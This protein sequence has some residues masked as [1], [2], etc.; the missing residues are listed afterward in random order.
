ML[1]RVRLELEFDPEPL[2]AEVDCLAAD[3]WVPHF[4]TDYYEGD[5]SGV[6]LRSVGGR[7]TQLYPDPAAS[8]PFADTA[9][10]AGSPALGEALGR[11]QCELLS[12]RLLRL[13]PG[14]R[15]REHR[16]YNLG[17]EDGEIRLHIPLSTSSEVEFLHQG[18]PVEMA[19]GECWYLDLN[20]PHAVSNRGDHERVHLVVD[21]V[22]NPWLD[23]LLAA[24]AAQDPS[25]LTKAAPMP[26]PTTD[27]IAGVPQLERLRRSIV[28]ER[29]RPREPLSRE[30]FV[31]TH[32]VLDTLGIGLEPVH[33]FMFRKLPTAVEFEQWVIRQSGG[34]LDHGRVD[35]ANRI[36]EGL[37]P[38][39]E[40]AAEMERLEQAPP[41]LSDE[42]LAFFDENGYVILR[43]AAP[44][45][46]RRALEQAIWEFLDAD[47]DDPKTWYPD[48][49]QQGIMVQMFRAPGIS[50]IH[51]SLRIRKA[52]AQLARTSDL[53]MTADRCGF[54]PPVVP[55]RSWGGAKLHLDLEDLSP[56]VAPGLQGI[57]YLT[58]TTEEQGAFRCVPGFHHRIDDWL[59]SL[60]ERDRDPRAQDLERLGARSIAGKAGD[61]IIWTQALPHGSQPN[62]ASRPR[63][64]HYLT[65]YPTPRSRAA[66][67]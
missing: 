51:A 38:S 35:S 45:E 50:E 1:S 47:P 41:V 22:V 42:D 18:E 63:L 60:E 62:L 44:A 9:L 43:D 67:S 24:S 7:P 3:D 2:R 61:L 65:M 13:G 46:A 10:L 16:D 64:V 52:F 23:E 33:T 12:A 39:P 66:R 15:I 5:W 20:L 49:L 17:Y 57:L 54:N 37:P 55:G 58:D 59:R 14:A 28:G 11:L 29:D 48:Q 53:V 40:A 30:E 36:A 6:A 8:E 19:A 56:P 31:V 21:C 27:T 34:A 26:E 4:N 25:C 32:A